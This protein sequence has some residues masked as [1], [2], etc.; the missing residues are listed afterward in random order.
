MS[1]KQQ[2]LVNASFDG[3]QVQI[4][5]QDDSITCFHMIWLRDNCRCDNCGDPAIGRRKLLLTNLQLQQTINCLSFQDSLLEVEWSDGHRS[6]YKADWLYRHAYDHEARLKRSF[7]PSSWAGNFFD[8]P[9]RL[10]FHDVMGDDEKLMLV[11]QSIRDYGLCL[12]S[13]SPAKSGIVESLALKIGYPQESNFGRIQD[14][15][16]DKNKA[17]VANDVIGLK[18]HTDEPYRASPPG[19]LMFHCIET[20]INGKG[21]SLFMDGFSIADQLRKEDPAGFNAL[22]QHPHSF[23]R[24]F[25]NDVD[26][27][28]E[29]PMIS[30]DEFGHISG[31]RINDRVAA[32]LSIP[33]DAV[34]DYYRGLKRLLE[35]SEDESR[36]FKL[37]LRPGDIA[38]FDNHRVLHGR[39][40][41]TLNAKR[42]LQWAQVERGDFHSTLRILSDK[43]KIPRD[44]NPFLRG[45]YG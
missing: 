15:I 42:W 17:S 22:C 34:E 1:E 11:L 39:T 24:H 13:D 7:S 28:A 3:T 25:A 45:S 6:G 44:A 10:K 33:F 36:M 31:I 27:I 29:F 30:I 38:L 40:Q 5:W 12:I 23:R 32:P 20:D 18:P 35:L 19:V 9:P 43:L 16:V 21:A 4:R 14:L 8:N 37:T 26:L 41:L 2:I